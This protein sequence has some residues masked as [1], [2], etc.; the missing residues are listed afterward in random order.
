LFPLALPLAGR[1]KAGSQFTTPSI[2]LR[3]M[4]SSVV[5]GLILAL[6][7]PY[8][9]HGCPF[10]ETL[11]EAMEELPDSVKDLPFTLRPKDFQSITH[12]L[13]EVG[14]AVQQSKNKG[15]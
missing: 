12:M 10:L 14:A 5:T 6:I 4:E 7:F 8:T 15:L 13:K 3:A 9:A 1:L 11:R 2:D